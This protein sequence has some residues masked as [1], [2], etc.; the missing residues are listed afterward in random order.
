M[1]F[2]GQFIPGGGHLERDVVEKDCPRLMLTVD[3]LSL[4]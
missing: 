2:G 1:T 4:I 3:K